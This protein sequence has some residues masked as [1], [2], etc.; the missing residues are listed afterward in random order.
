MNRD[1]PTLQILAR[2]RARQVGFYVCL[3]HLVR[4]LAQDARRGHDVPRRLQRRVLR[5]DAM[6]S[7]S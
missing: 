6:I 7:V 1:A 2:K 3:F 4:P 5:D